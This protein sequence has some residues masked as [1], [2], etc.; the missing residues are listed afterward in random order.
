MSEFWIGFLA[1][2]IGLPAVLVV[3]FLLYV[4]VTTLIDRR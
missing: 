2:F 3:L 4:G 1:G